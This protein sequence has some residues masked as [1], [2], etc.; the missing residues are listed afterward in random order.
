MIE[1]TVAPLSVFIVGGNAPEKTP[2]CKK[3]ETRGDNVLWE[4]YE[5]QE[6]CQVSQRP[7]MVLIDVFLN[8]PKAY[9]EAAIN[10]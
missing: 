8:F 10:L 1:M 4:K 5:M 6:A 3:I 9:I 7:N 2:R